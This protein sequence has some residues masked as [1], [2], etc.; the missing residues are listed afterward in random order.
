MNRSLLFCFALLP[1]LNWGAERD[2][3]AELRAAQDWL[4]T[5]PLPSVNGLQVVE[6]WTGGTSQG[7]GGTR[8]IRSVTV[9]GFLLEETKE[10]IAFQN[11]W[12]MKM[13]YLVKVEPNNPHRCRCEK[14]TLEWAVMGEL[15][16][17]GFDHG[18]GGLQ[19]PLPADKLRWLMLARHCREFGDAALKRRVDEWIIE[20]LNLETSTG[21]EVPLLI[22]EIKNEAAAYLLQLCY[23][24]FGMPMNNWQTLIDELKP[25]HERCP[26]T[27]DGAKALMLV[28][29]LQSYIDEEKQSPVLS[30]EAIQELPSDQRAVQLIRRL[31]YQQM[32]WFNG[33]ENIPKELESLG[34]QTFPALLDALDDHRPCRQVHYNHFKGWD[35]DGYLRSVGDLVMQI[36]SDISGQYFRKISKTGVYESPGATAE[37][38]A[39]YETW[40]KHE[41]EK[42]EQQH[43]IELV[44]SGGPDMVVL[45]RRLM[46][47]YP[48]VAGGAIVAGYA[49]LKL[50]HE[51][52]NLLWG[53][54]KL[55]D[56]QLVTLLRNELLHGENLECR[57][58]AAMSLRKLGHASDA[59]MLE[60]WRRLEERGHVAGSDSV[61]RFLASSQSDSVIDQL[62][63][64]LRGRP[65]YARIAVIQHLTDAF[66]KAVWN[67]DKRGTLKTRKLIEAVLASELVD[68]EESWGHSGVGYRNPCAGDFAASGLAKLLPKEYSF[69]MG[70]SYAARAEARSR[71]SRHWHEKTGTPWN[72]KPALAGTPILRRHEIAQVSFASPILENSATETMLKSFVGQDLVSERLVAL[73]CDFGSTLPKGV[74]GIRVRLVRPENARGIQVTVWPRAGKH[75]ETWED[76]HFWSIITVGQ[77][78][79]PVPV[80]GSRLHQNIGDPKNWRD[81]QQALEEVLSNDSTSELVVR[82]GVESILHDQ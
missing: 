47:M 45:S 80:H 8:E 19:G 81:F 14:R 36:L 35:H 58:A 75:P 46:T 61:I 18:L 50:P 64:S 44:S 60:E 24:Q 15:K 32:T 26:D 49:R 56:P 2:N 43:L 28:K 65:V 1:C 82:I 30:L 77:K 5:I 6:I 51:K 38:R 13:A 33:T 72:P 7:G 71:L 11:L 31:R 9:P 16:N 27:P 67:G 69:E 21:R 23:R 63:K 29:H 34:I 66:E 78:D 76:F 68:D 12:L 39:F 57:A 22:D 10:H 54:G 41:Q 4:E 70:G 37:A 53:L 17:Q 40:W 79:L 73:L 62:A 42:G 74:N 3:A 55:N 25:I 52:Q 59:E 20:K 48:H